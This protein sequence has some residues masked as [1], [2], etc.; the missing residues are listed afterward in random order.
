MFDKAQDERRLKN[1]HRQ[2]RPAREPARH[3]SVAMESEQNFSMFAFET[4]AKT[5]QT[6]PRRDSGT[7][8][9]NGEVRHPRQV[10]ARNDMHTEDVLP[11][12]RLGGVGQHSHT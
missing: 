9:E 10:A 11:Q 5:V 7:L 6:T 2:V 8:D 4:A 12:N 1:V 3:G